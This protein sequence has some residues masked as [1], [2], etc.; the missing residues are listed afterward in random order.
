MVYYGVIKK[1][2][3]SAIYY[4]TEEVSGHYTKRNK[5][6]KKKQLLYDSTFIGFLSS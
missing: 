4:N 3:T 2:G 1:E 6:F 5:Q